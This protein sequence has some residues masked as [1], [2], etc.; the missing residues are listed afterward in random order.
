M[1]KECSICNQNINEEN[2]KLNGTILKVRNENK[3]IQIIP[4]CSKCMKEDDWMTVAK[5]KAA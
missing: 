3:E 5:I 2:G 1:K 4:V